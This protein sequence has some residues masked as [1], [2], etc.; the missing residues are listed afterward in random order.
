MRPVQQPRV[1]IWTAAGWPRRRPLRRAANWDG[2]YLM[3][4]HQQTG[5]LLTPQDVSEVRA[6]VGTERS[7]SAPFDIAINGEVPDH[8]HPESYVAAFEEAGAT[9]WVWVALHEATVDDYR[10]RI[11]QGPPRALIS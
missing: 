9:W 1:P 11:G 6:L 4:V 2:V 10:R 5:R 3:T 8:A 7:S